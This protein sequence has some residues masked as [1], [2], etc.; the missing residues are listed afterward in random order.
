MTAQGSARARASGKGP[1]VGGKSVQPERFRQVGRPG[2]TAGRRMDRASVQP[3]NLV[4]PPCAG[5]H[6]RARTY[7]CTRPRFTPVFFSWAFT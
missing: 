4:Q 5:A 6:G 2:W 7:A 3:S 1:V